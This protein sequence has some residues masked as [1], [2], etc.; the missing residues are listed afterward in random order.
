MKYGVFIVLAVL[1][2][3]CTTTQKRAF[4]HHDANVKDYQWLSSRHTGLC[5]WGHRPV[6]LPALRPFGRAAVFGRRCRLHHLGD[7]DAH[8]LC[9]RMGCG[10]VL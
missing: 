2:C 1:F 4:V 7:A 3:S 8:H 5:F 9:H 10:A 6:G